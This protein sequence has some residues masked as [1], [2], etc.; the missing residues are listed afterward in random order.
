MGPRSAR[1]AAINCASDGPLAGSLQ[2]VLAIGVR[3]RSARSEKIREFG[4]K[5]RFTNTSTSFVN[6]VRHAHKLDPHTRSFGRQQHVARARVP[7][8]GTPDAS[9]IDE[10]HT[11]DRPLPRFVSMTEAN[12]ILR[13]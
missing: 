1:P 5:L 9:R 12:D 4:W 10:L 11:L 3:R 2:F 7:V 6:V 13:S 8:L